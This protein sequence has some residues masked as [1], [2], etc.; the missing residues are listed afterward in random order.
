MAD[1]RCDTEGSRKGIQRGAAKR[2]EGSFDAGDGGDI[3]PE[4]W[5]AVEPSM[6]RLVNGLPNRVSQL[7]ALGNS[8]VPQIAQEIG[9][10]I[11]EAEKWKP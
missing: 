4:E 9:N 3:R 8:I 6:G 7:R 2:S 5:W 1:P 11:K 10:A